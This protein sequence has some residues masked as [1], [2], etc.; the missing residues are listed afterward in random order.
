M[1][2]EFKFC[3]HCSRPLQIKVDGGDK[4]LYCENCRKYQ[5]RNPTVGVA[6]VYVE[7][8]RL[9]LVRRTGS[10]AGMWCIPCGHVEREEDVRHAAQREFEE[11]TGL[12]VTI[13]PV[14]AVHSNFHDPENPTV[15]IWF[16][17][18]NSRGSLRAGS[19]ASE[20]GYFQI[21]SLPD[22]MAFPTDLIVC[23]KL[24][25]CLDSD[26]FESWLGSCRAY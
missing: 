3:P 8:D 15:G 24:R 7:D 2:V 20:V 19:D 21:D 17:G 1:T 10:Y 25:H 9:L 16:W 5:Y 6:V 12:E 22:R 26:D 18:T 23:E 4:R 11:E 13:G 14:F